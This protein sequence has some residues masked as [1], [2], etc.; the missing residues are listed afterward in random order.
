MI[1]P[2]PEVCATQ[3]YQLISG[4]DKK[5]VI[6]EMLSVFQ[7]TDVVAPTRY[8]WNVRCSG[9]AGVATAPQDWMFT[10]RSTSC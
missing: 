6:P 4:G 2:E 10:A 9:Q 1:Y 3:P 8:R 5:V 7:L